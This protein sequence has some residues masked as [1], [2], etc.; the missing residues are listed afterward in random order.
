MF[1][2][3]LLPNLTS[4]Y[5]QDIAKFLGLMKNS[6]HENVRATTMANSCVIVRDLMKAKSKLWDH[7]LQMPRQGWGTACKASVVVCSLKL[8]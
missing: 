5:P 2:I 3:Y 4:S 7:A 8:L 6:T 1:Q